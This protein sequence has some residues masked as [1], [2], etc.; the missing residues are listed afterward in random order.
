MKRYVGK[1]QN[2]QT[3]AQTS[4]ESETGLE[5][6][7]PEYIFE[8]E[9]VIS[10]ATPN[11]ATRT[12]LAERVRLDEQKCEEEIFLQEVQSDTVGLES[13]SIAEKTDRDRNREIS[14]GR[15]RRLSRFS[16]FL[17]IYAAVFLVI[18][19]IG[20]TFFWKYIAA[21]EISRPE[22]TMDELMP[23]MSE[24]DGTD[25]LKKYFEVSE[26]EDKDAVISKIYSTYLQDQSCTYRKMPGEYADDSPVYMIRSG[27]TD[28]FKVNLA[29][30]GENA[31]GYGFQLW[32]VS[33]I[34]LLK[35]NARTLTIEAP[36][37]SAVS[38][39]GK[40]V[41]KDYIT[42]N[43]VEY[44]NL[45][46]FEGELKDGVYR[47]L[48]SIDGIYDEVSVTVVDE[49]GSEL[50]AETAESNKFVYGSNRL[51]VKVA[52]PADA[53]ITINGIELSE[54][55]VP[56]ALV[57][58]ELLKGLEKYSGSAPAF[59]IYEVNGLLKTPEIAAK[60]ASGQ[61]LVSRKGLDGEVIFG[62]PD[63]ENLIKEHTQL[64]TDFIKTYVSFSTNEGDNASENFSRLSKR[65]LPNTETY[66]R[67][68]NS[69]EGI[70]WV[71][72]GAIEYRKLAIDDIILCGKD[73]FVCRVSLGIT[74]TADGNVRD[75]D[76]IYTLVFVRS[77][78]VWLVGNMDTE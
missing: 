49:Q 73:C 51:S 68:K 8:P 78:G 72:D 45:S 7:I 22:N 34:A 15:K 30:K 21:Y 24:N 27:T 66:K 48:Y 54:E 10:S 57:S 75:N 52:A 11:S 29:P 39:N 33:A 32:E 3:E 69:I 35:D 71:T 26:F 19:A 64:I 2:R 40:A 67:I 60:D 36:P 31:A 53:V 55:D 50:T 63:N 76:S 56:Q 65:L 44:E 9:P 25:S 46:K 61:E 5:E 1:H 12:A 77:S 14:S 17:L 28:L 41:S 6:F 4:Q 59:V 23:L 58:P 47:V 38:I 43:Q 74:V 70:S 20:L 16:R 18:I 37:T 62:L 42:D 13:E